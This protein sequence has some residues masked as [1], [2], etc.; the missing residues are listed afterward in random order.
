[1]SKLDLKPDPLPSSDDVRAYI[2][3]LVA[4]LGGLA[5]A[6]DQPEL[7]QDLKRVGERHDATVRVKGH[8]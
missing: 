5:R 4:E 3:Q 8:V 1:M 6:Y 2:L 7:A